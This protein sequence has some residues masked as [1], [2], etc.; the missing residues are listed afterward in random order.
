[1]APTIRLLAPI[2]IA[3]HIDALADVLIDC[4][5][6]GASVNFMAGLTP[7]RAAA[8]WRDVS[9]CDDGRVIAVAEDGGRIV[10]TAQMI[11]APQDNQP[12]RA[13]V[14]KMLVH[15]DCRRMGLGAALLEAVETAAREAGRTL[16]TLDTASDDAA[17]LYE[18]GGFVFAGRIPGYALLPDGALCDTML[19]FKRLA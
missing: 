3:R 18:R 19:Y 10:G 7:A 1:M 5:A 4:V 15:S 16:M 2:A 14:A 8:F 6:H 9:E 11:P 12:H 17:R 13:E